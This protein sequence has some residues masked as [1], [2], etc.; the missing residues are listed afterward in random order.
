LRRKFTRKGEKK[1]NPTN[2]NKT[3]RKV[4][5]TSREGE[6][7]PLLNLTYKRKFTQLSSALG[8]GE[9]ELLFSKEIT[10]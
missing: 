5:K 4:P 9:V 7:C 3:K 6:S 10:S 1:K 8:G 2:S